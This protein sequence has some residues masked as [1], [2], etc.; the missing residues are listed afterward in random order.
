MILLVAA[1]ELDTQLITTNVFLSRW[2]LDSGLVSVALE[3]MYRSENI[4]RSF[5]P[6]VIVQKRQQKINRKTEGGRGYSVN[7]L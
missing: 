2:T 1:D 3:V 7:I 6:L 4:T 5:Q